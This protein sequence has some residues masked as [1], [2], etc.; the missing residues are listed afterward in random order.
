MHQVVQ[1]YQDGPNGG[2]G[3]LRYFTFKPAENTIYAYTYSPTR[4]GGLGQFDTD[5]QSQFTLN[6]S[7]QGTPF[8]AL[9]TALQVASGS[10][11]AVTWSGLAPNTRYEWY[12]TVS[13]GKTTT[14]GPTWT[15][16]T[17]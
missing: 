5:A 15:F 8:A 17:Q 6:Y 12:A 14:V 1:D 16:T 7:M 2:D 11:A 4:N 3:W 9:G 13:D 10:S